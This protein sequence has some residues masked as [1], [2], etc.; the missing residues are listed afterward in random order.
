MIKMNEVALKN[1]KGQLKNGYIDMSTLH[2]EDE[3]DLLENMVKIYENW[4]ELKKW[5]EEE[6]KGN[7]SWYGSLTQH[8]KQYY[9]YK[10]NTKK[11]ILNNMQDKMQEL[12]QK[13][14]IKKVEIEEQEYL[15]IL[16]AKLLKDS[17]INKIN[18]TTEKIK[19]KDNIEDVIK[20]INEINNYFKEDEVWQEYSK[21]NQLFMEIY[22]TC[23]IANTKGYK[24]E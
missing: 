7:I 1:I 10:F 5:L 9:L 13:K 12:K 24:N 19:N 3:I 23:L 22:N 11:I 21:M 8:D 18:E 2:E 15:K 4:N 6:H 17:T 20:D 16:N 14:D